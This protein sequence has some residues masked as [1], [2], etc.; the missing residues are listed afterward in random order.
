MAAKPQV[1]VIDAKVVVA[2]NAKPRAPAPKAP[3]AAAAAV[4]AALAVHDTNETSDKKQTPPLPEQGFSGED[5][6][7]ED[8]KTHTDDWQNEY[9]HGATTL[10]PTPVPTKVAARD[11][12]LRASF[13]R[14]GR[15]RR[16]P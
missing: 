12:K 4:P 3:I 13:G 10:A 6:V 8:G 7:H 11:A 14:A 15:S 2:G 1:K 16:D 9:G 5:V